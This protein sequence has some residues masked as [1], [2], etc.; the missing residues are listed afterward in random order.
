MKYVLTIVIVIAIVL[1]V[2]YVRYA[3]EVARLRKSLDKQMCSADF[4]KKY[5]PFGIGKVIC[6]DEFGNTTTR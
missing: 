2:Q 6:K 5:F 4:G 3:S 1:I